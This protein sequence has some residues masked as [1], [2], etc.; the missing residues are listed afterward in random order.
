M[1]TRLAKAVTLL[2]AM[3]TGSFAVNAFA[4]WQWIGKDGRQVFSDRSPPTEVRDKDILKRPAGAARAADAN[5]ATANPAAKPTSEASTLLAPSTPFIK[6]SAPKLS[7][8]DAELETKKKKAEADEVA[9]KKADDEKLAS[10]KAENCERAKSALA[11]LRSGVRMSA[12][13]AKG[14]T[15][16]YDDVKRQSES[17][18][19]QDTIDSNCK[20][21]GSAPQSQAQ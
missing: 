20:S 12:T 17:K 9:K 6:A 19:A 5:E 1:N 8:K 10:V 2:L 18:R 14:E 7:G 3:T 13:N 16:I 21:S 11:T 4:Q 15:E